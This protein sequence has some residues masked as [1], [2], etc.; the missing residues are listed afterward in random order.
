MKKILSIV[1]SAV[2]FASLSVTSFAM[3]VPTTS[4]IGAYMTDEEVAESENF[5][6]QCPELAEEYKN[7][8]KTPLSTIQ[9]KASAAVLSS[10][11]TSFIAS[12]YDSDNNY[13][14]NGEWLNGASKTEKDYNGTVYIGTLEVGYGKEYATFNG[15]KLS[16][17][18]CV[19][20]DINGDRIVDEFVD[21]WK[22]TN[23]TSGT[24]NSHC[25]STNS[26]NGNKPT[27]YVSLKVK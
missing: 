13:F 3:T 10:Y 25:T 1:T 4:K 11:T 7:A 9:A 2:V 23:V 26:K 5:L 17:V 18:D 21:V 22:V 15:N 19:P 12:S 27:Y 14:S 16:E 20:L 24:F 8:A 6:N